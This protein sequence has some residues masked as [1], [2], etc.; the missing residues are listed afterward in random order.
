MNISKFQ[1]ALAG[2]NNILVVFPKDPDFDAVSAGLSLSLS[3][4]ALGKKTGVLCISPMLVEFNRLVGVEKVTD[5]IGSKNITIS[6]RDYPASDIERV[7]Y[8]IENGEMQ[9]TIIP[10]PDVAPP[11]TDQIVSTYGGLAA[12]LVILMGVKNDEQIGSGKY[13]EEINKAGQKIVI[14]QEYIPQAFPL[15]QRSSIEMVDANASCLSEIVG[16]LLTQS[17]LPL[18][19]DIAS[20]LLSGITTATRNFTNNR[21]RPETFDLS[22]RLLRIARSQEVAQKTQ[23][24]DQDT[25]DKNAPR[26]WL[27]PKVYKGNTFP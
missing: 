7:S 14:L 27:E 21:V 1:E 12:E 15:R 25:S 16:L 20:N 22:G 10:K 8:N 23:S 13:I 5:K 9:L 6:L 2:V 4:S 17:N 18:D 3:L 24:E 19:Q 26:E 11:N